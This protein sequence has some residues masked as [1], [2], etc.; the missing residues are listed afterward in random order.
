M[1]S[2][3]A[4]PK[5]FLVSFPPQHTKPTSFFNVHPQRIPLLTTPN[6]ATGALHS[7][8][9]LLSL[10]A[11]LLLNIFETTDS[12][13]TALALSKTCHRLHDIWTSNADIILP[14]IVECFPQAQNLATTQENAIQ[15]QTNAQ[16]MS[17]VAPGIPITTNQRIS[18]NASLAS[19]ILQTFETHITSTPSPTTGLTRRTALTP[20]ER[21]SFLHGFYLAMTYVT[22]GRC[23]PFLFT[24]SMFS[25]MQM[26]EAMQMLDLHLTAS[27]T[28]SLHSHRSPETNM[29]VSE[30]V[31]DFKYFHADLRCYATFRFA[32][33]PG[34][35]DGW[36][37]APFGY[38]T[39]DDGYR[40]KMYEERGEGPLLHDVLKEIAKITLMFGG[41]VP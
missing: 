16:Q 14:S 30:T 12:F 6:M 1:T 21:T 38:F 37:K 36:H 39:L 4:A 32:R 15:E 11:E 20:T 35:R 29:T 19:H 41:H 5:N 34:E 9:T 27:P 26:F 40:A 22:L 23:F 2:T 3:D 10:P 8:K 25:Y 31:L 28:S 24:L 7:T 33:W 13:S 17:P 18:Q